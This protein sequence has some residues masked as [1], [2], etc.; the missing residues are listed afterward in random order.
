MRERVSPRTTASSC[1]LLQ[2]SLIN[3]SPR[4]EPTPHPRFA[5]GQERRRGEAGTVPPSVL[6]EDQ[7]LSVGRSQFHKCQPGAVPEPV[8]KC[9]FDPVCMGH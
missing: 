2:S 3:A 7:R 4:D 5:E 9:K 6:G 8:L 1:C